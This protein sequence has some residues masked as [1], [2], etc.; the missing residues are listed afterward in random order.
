MIIMILTR[1]SYFLT[2]SS[3]SDRGRKTNA[4]TS[5]T[6]A[7]T[8]VQQ[9]HQNLLSLTTPSLSVRGLRTNAPTSPLSTFLST[10]RPL[11]MSASATLTSKWSEDGNHDNDDG[12]GDV[13]EDD[14]HNC[15]LQVQQWRASNARPGCA[16][17]CSSRTDALPWFVLCLPLS[18]FSITSIK[19]INEK[20]MITLQSAPNATV[21][22]TERRIMEKLKGSQKR[23]FAMV[24]SLTTFER[25]QICLT[26]HWLAIWLIIFCIRFRKSRRE[27]GQLWKRRLL[28][29]AQGIFHNVRPWRY[30][31][32]SYFSLL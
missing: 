29:N 20:W 15:P 4:P 8:N 9:M 12:D 25:L 19:M 21:A 28:W 27:C 5:S 1:V 14:D 7:N 2:T 18:L 6:I 26:N 3:L 10:R 17:I 22:V 23:P 30:I 13:E 16:D 32:V 24:S 11:Q 31:N